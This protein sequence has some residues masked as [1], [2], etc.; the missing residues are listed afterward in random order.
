MKFSVPPAVAFLAPRLTRRRPREIKGDKASFFKTLLLTVLLVAGAARADAAH[1]GEGEST[2]LS[3]LSVQWGG[4]VK[5]RA[6]V[7]WPPS[8]SFLA[9]EGSGPLWDAQN[10]LRLVA[11]ASWGDQAK[12]EVHHESFF[13]AGDTLKLLSS[14]QASPYAGLA[15]VMNDDRRLM[16][17]TWTYR[18]SEDAV[19]VHRFDRLSASWFSP[20]GM[21]KAGRQAISWGDGMLFNP[22]DVLAPF[23]PTALDRDYKQGEDAL[24]V[25]LAPSGMPGDLQLVHVPR[26]EPSSGDLRWDQSSLAGKYRFFVPATEWE[27]TLLAGRHFDDFVAGAGAT[28]YVGGAACRINATWTWLEQESS[29]FASLVANVDYGWV[30]G[31]NFYGW[32]EYYYNG[33]GEGAGD[34]GDAWEREALADRLERGELFV[35]GRHYVDTQLRAELHPLLNLFLVTITNVTDPSGVVQPYLV[36]DLDENLQ[37]NVSGTIY[38]GSRET[39]YGGTP[40]TGTDFTDRPANNVFTWLTLYF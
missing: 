23:A 17:L 32:L 35:R 25:Q 20:W 5:S 6:A 34:Y 28:G 12:L 8:D 37:L 40:V 27:G 18:Q 14:S 38:W 2:E 9:G 39:E 4:H 11:D 1:D 30:W 3:P 13:L 24:L 26:R 16:D 21:V 7:S 10:E 19:F 15:G 31:I 22:F 36:W 29:G 33:L